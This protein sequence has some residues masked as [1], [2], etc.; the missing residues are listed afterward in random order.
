MA[1]VCVANVVWVV[2][3]MSASAVREVLGIRNLDSKATVPPGVLT[4]E[5]VPA[6]V[7]FGDSTVDA[8]NNNYMDTIVKS[9]FL[10]YGM[11]FAGHVPTGR[12]TD[13]LLATDFVCK[14][15]PLSSSQGIVRLLIT[16]VLQTSQLLIF[17]Y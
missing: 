17:F 9:N 15:P 13:G 8:G 10:P 7:V 3:L 16:H 5:Q 1:S 6:L 2:M 12:F 14:P 4:K 11:N